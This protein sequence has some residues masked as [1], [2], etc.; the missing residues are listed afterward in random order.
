MVIIYIVLFKNM[1][2]G[3]IEVGYISFVKMKFLL[4]E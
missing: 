4:M 2:I 3:Q 1:S